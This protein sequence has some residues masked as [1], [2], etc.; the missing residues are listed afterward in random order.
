VVTSVSARTGPAGVHPGNYQTYRYHVSVAVTND[1]PLELP[2]H[3]EE[4]VAAV[5]RAL[6]DRCGVATGDTLL[7]A[8]SGGADSAALLLAMQALAQR[9][10]HDYELHVGHV[11]HG[12]RGEASLEDARAVDGWCASIDV[13]CT[14]LPIDVE[15]RVETNVEAA[16]RLG[17]YEALAELAERLGARAVVA[18]HHQDDHLET[19]LMALSRGAGPR[20][21]AGLTWRRDLTPEVE[22]I[23]PMLAVD[24]DWAERLCKT[25]GLAWR[26]DATNR[27]Q[28]RTRATIR[29]RLA[30][31]L[32]AL[33]PGTAERLVESAQVWREAA[34]ALAEKA[35]GVFGDADT[36]ARRDLREQPIGVLTEGFRA[37]IL[38]LTAGAG[39]DRLSF[40][41]LLTCAEAVRDDKED[42]RR[43]QI[44]AGV[45]IVVRSS[46]VTVHRITHTADH[47]G[48]T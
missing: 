33:R 43:F 32:A 20:G 12:L 7:L 28:S 22:L 34:D 46:L 16:A 26:D 31:E 48:S 27:D 24:H 39:A 29:T 23:R 45:E 44:L 41:K 21:L 18:A 40:R 17:R 1:P 36:W 6:R 25:A 8:V 5:G 47:G 14:I 42:P 38:R 3:R 10:E 19:I 13:A 37:A 2:D 15:V 9:R 4:G 11:E 35:A 30:P